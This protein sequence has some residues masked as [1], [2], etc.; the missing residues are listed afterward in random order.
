MKTWGLSANGKIDSDKKTFEVNITGTVFVLK[1][2]A[3]V[4]IVLG[5]IVPIATFTAN[6]FVPCKYFARDSAPLRCMEPKV[7]P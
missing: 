2:F 4:L 5:L 6:A 3:C 1:L 7:T